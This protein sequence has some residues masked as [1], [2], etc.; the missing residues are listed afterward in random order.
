[1]TWRRTE[2]CEPPYAHFRRSG[3]RLQNKSS[4]PVWSVST[5]EMFCS[6]LEVRFIWTL[7]RNL[8]LRTN[9]YLLVLGPVLMFGFLK[10]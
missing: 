8:Q 10:L 1:M 6:F 3:A 4:E 2:S 5:A 9:I 7:V